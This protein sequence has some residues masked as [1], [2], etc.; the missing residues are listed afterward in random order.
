MATISNELDELSSALMG[1][2]LDALADEGEVD[3]LLV[4]ELADG[5]VESYVF[6]DDGPEACL[7]GARDK[8]RATA[9]AVRY[10]IAYEG[11]VEAEDGAYE[12]A[13]IL[14]FGERGWHS[15]SAYS[16]VMGKGMGEEFAWTDP[17]PAGELE[18][19]LG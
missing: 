9:D 13:L 15:F 7:D 12:D 11:A 14:E 16:L 1:D 17:A 8:V 2:A 4:C 6:A 18:P 3:V 19:L 10:A 5:T